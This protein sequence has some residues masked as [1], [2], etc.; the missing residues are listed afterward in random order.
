MVNQMLEI[1]KFCFEKKISCEITYEEDDNSFSFDEK[2]VNININNKDEK[3]N[4]IFIQNI[5]NELKQFF[6]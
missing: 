2:T 5:L 4:L 6:N 1:V 3:E